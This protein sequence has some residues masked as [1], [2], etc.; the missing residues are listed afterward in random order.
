MSPEQVRARELDPRSDLFSFGAVL[1]EMATGVR[2]FQGESPAVICEAILSRTPVPPSQLNRHVP[3]AL[4]DIIDKALQK[5]CNRRYQRASEMRAD[6]ESLKGTGA[7]AAAPPARGG[8]TWKALAGALA[9]VAVVA[10]G[11]R[12]SVRRSLQ[13][14][15]KDTIVL[16]DFVNTTGEPVFDDTL[17]QGLSV[18]LL[19][20]PFLNILPDQTLGE[21]LRLMGRAPGD[22]ITPQ[23]AREAC[24]RTNGKAMLAGSISRLGSQY[25]LGLRAQECN[26]GAD[27]AQEQ[28][29]APRKEDVLKALDKAAGSVRRALG[30]SLPSRRCRRT[31]SG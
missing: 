11:I 14:T 2:P 19:Q 18:K 1:Y 9:A 3:P 4:Q 16:A 20:S 23:L 26:S 24:V 5:D 12:Y 28:V 27:L 22:A 25:V 29:E 15:E 30:E 21:T 8:L 17:K 10:A 6:L 13:L 31:A 7:I